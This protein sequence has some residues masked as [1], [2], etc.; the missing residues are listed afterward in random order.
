V[1]VP[2]GGIVLLVTSMGS[3]GPNRSHP[4]RTAAPVYGWEPSF[5]Q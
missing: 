3:K 2:F 4:G 5:G 1:L